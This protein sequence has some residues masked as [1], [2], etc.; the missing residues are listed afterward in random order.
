MANNKIRC[1]L[2]DQE[3]VNVQQIPMKHCYSYECE[4]CGNYAIT[5][6]AIDLSLPHK[7]KQDKARLSALTKERSL[8]K[9][10]PT[11]ITTDN[12]EVLLATFPSGPLQRPDRALKNLTSL[13]SK[14]PWKPISLTYKKHYPILFAEDEDAFDFVLQALEDEKYI[15]VRRERYLAY[16]KIEY[17]DAPLVQ[18]TSHG[19]KRIEELEKQKVGKDSNQAFVAMSF[20]DSL[21]CPY[22]EGIEKAIESTGYKPF[23]VDLKAHN[24]KIC[25]LIISEIRKSHFMVADFTGHRGGV[26][27]EAGF[28]L[29]LGIDVIWTCREDDKDDLHFDTRQYNHI[30]W[31]DEKDLFERLKARIEATI[32]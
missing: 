2:C 27:F 10:E 5:G 1:L 15:T 13:L 4:T 25:D 28:A 14:S 22:K 29:G 20:D 32:F 30:F 16:D 8:H 21:K 7:S 19:W 9:M 31:K 12:I 11:M 23:R 17:I 18:L 26:Y 24:E 3:G 6:Q